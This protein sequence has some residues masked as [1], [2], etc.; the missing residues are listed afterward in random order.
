ML[1]NQKSPG[2]G[3]SVAKYKV[4]EKKSFKGLKRYTYFN[5]RM[6]K[7]ALF[8]CRECGDCSLPDITYLCPQSQCAKNQRNGPCGGS[9]NDKCELSE[10]NRDCIWVKAYS[11]NKYFNKNTVEHLPSIPVI[12]NSKLKDTSGWANYYLGRDHNAYKLDRKSNN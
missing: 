10:H 5:E 2:F 8:N 12:K 3:V 7:A 1:F 11:R 9:S 6:I 4:L